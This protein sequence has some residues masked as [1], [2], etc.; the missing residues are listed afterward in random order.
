MLLL[1]FGGG[2]VHLHLQRGLLENEKVHMPKGSSAN[3]IPTKLDENNSDKV[4]GISHNLASKRRKL[5]YLAAENIHSCAK[6]TDDEAKAATKNGLWHT[7]VTNING[8]EITELCKKSKTIGKVVITEIVQTS[9]KSFE[10]STK[11]LIR[12]VSVLYRGGM[13]SK[14]KYSSIR[15]SEIFDYDLVQKKRRQMEFD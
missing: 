5:T 15:S 13:L 9:I 11:N 1:L 3:V 6:A 10:K 4:I 12:S 7:L 14:R 8:S 2:I